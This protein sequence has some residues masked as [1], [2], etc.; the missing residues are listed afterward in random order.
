[1][2]SKR[3]IGVENTPPC[4]LA[5][6][7]CSAP[8]SKAIAEIPRGFSIE[9]WLRLAP[10]GRSQLQSVPSQAALTRVPVCASTA[11]AEIDFSCA[12]KV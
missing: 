3:S 6:I 9:S 7:T 10:L 2:G 12:V 5:T 11:R 4:A 8:G 1:M